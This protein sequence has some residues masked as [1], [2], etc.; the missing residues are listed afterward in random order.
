MTFSEWNACV[1]LKVQGM[2]NLHDALVGAP[3]DF[4]VLFSSINGVTGQHGQVNYTVTNAF[5]DALVRY[6]HSE[7]LVASVI[8]IGVMGD[9][10]V[11]AQDERLAN[12]FRRAGYS[13][14]EEQDLLDGLSIA[15][16]NSHSQRPSSSSSSS[17]S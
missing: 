2:W 6:R 12:Q 17:S 1:Q 15:M 14:L 9:I 11:V 16:A 13:M 3:L 5:P 10:D 4:F 8:D 7:G